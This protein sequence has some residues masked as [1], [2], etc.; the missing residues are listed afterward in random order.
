MMMDSRELQK[1]VAEQIDDATGA[2]GD[3]LTTERGRLSDIYFGEPY[4]DETEFRS[5]IVSTDVA[6]TIEW[7]MPALMDI[8]TGGEHVVQF[9][10][11]GP[12]DEER[13]RQETDVVTHVLMRKNEGWLAFYSWFK[14]A[15]IQKN[16]YVKRYWHE[17]ET[18]DVE[19][20]EGLSGDDILAIFQSWQAEGREAEIEEYEAD[21]EGLIRIRARLR[22]K[23]EC[24]RVECV[25][26]EEVIVSPRWRSV[27]LDDCPFIAH[28]P[29]G[30]TV[31]DLVAAGYDR[32]QVEKLS[33]STEQEISDERIRRFDTAD[34]EEE[35]NSIPIGKAG[36]S[37]EVHEC[38]IRVDRNDDGIA[39]LVKVTVAGPGREI[40]K[41]ADGKEDIEEVAYQP[42]SALTPVI[43]PHRHIGRSI[44][45]LVDDLQR[46]KTVL[47]RQM[48]D[49]VYLTNNPTREIARD[50]IIEGVTISDLLV[51]RPGKIIRT[52]APGHYAEHSPPQFMAQLLPAIEY[53]DGVRENRT[54]VTR[55]NQGLDANSL[56]KT[57]HGMQQIMSAADKKIL[58]IAR[59]FAETGVKHLVRGIH[60]DLRRHATKAMTIKLRGGWVPVN[61]RHWRDRSDLEVNVALGT[62]NREQRI[63]RLMAVI[64]K[65]EAHAMNGSPLVTPQNLYH[66]LAKLTEEAGFKNPGQFF[67]DPAEAP[68]QPQQPQ[69]DPA[70]VAMQIEQ[71][72]AQAK[73]QGDM[74]KVQAKAAADQQ[75]LAFEAQKAAMEDDRERDRLNVQTGVEL[76]KINAA[77]EAKVTSAQIAAQARATQQ[78]N[79]P[80]E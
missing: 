30:K 65:Q 56:N 45:E 46:I 53:I 12:D 78:V 62:G 67:T 34:H 4:G 51:D 69:S 31:S 16:G 6:D 72:K 44:A 26:P 64:E 58:L 37:I 42:F 13:A 28:R 79:R 27:T 1:I 29:S 57:A 36:R 49:N 60:A 77:N 5:Q 76:A 80:G 7:I 50:G 24:E 8:M 70:Q 43:V 18:D 48:L 25:P 39:E 59:I 2:I 38:Y 9:E 66:G 21:E 41:W 63:A 47:T 23:V 22:G 40:L 75:R 10:P 19:E 20:Y 54:G 74:A 55:Y 17:R 52:A 3:Q 61:P 73:M 71:M 15:L 32:K 14:D 11:L 68:P 33:D 35:E